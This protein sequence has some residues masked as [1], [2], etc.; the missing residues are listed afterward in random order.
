MGYHVGR[1]RT[2]RAKLP[3]PIH[4]RVGLLLLF[5]SIPPVTIAQNNDDRTATNDS[6]PDRNIKAPISNED[7]EWA[8]H[9]AVDFLWHQQKRVGRW[10]D[11]R[12]SAPYADD[13]TALA[14]YALYRTGSSPD[15]RQFDRA[16][17]YLLD[18]TK[19]PAVFARAHRL[20]LFSSIGLQYF[21]IPIQKDVHFLEVHQ[22]K[23]GAWGS[24]VASDPGDDDKSSDVFHTNLALRALHEAA[25]A[26]ATVTNSVWRRAEQTVLKSQNEDGGWGYT[27]STGEQSSAGTQ[28][29]IG[30]MTA[31]ALAALDIIY[32][33]RYLDAELPFNGRFKAKCGKDVEK[34]QVIRRATR[35]AFTWLENH[36]SVDT[37]PGLSTEAIDDPIVGSLPYHLAQ[38]SGT[39]QLTGPN[40]AVRQKWIRKIATRLIRSQRPD[41]SWGS[42][43]ETSHALLA[44]SDARAPLL[45]SKLV[46]G[47]A[48]QWNLDPRDAVHLTQWCKEEF[49]QPFAWQ[50]V[51]L[52]A[53]EPDINSAPVLLINGHEAPQLTAKQE[54]H[55]RSFVANGGT[56]LASACCSRA[57][58]TKGCG[59]LFS[60]VFPDF[61]SGPL[62]A[63]HAV[64]NILD[65]VKPGEDCIGWGDGCRTSLFLLPNGACCAWQQD[66]RSRERRRFALAGNIVKYATYYQPL[67]SLLKTDKPDPTIVPFATTKVAT[68][69]HGGDSWAEPGALANLRRI[70]A[71]RNGVELQ[72]MPP[73]TASQAADRGVDVLWLTGHTFG[74]L[75]VDEEIALR[76]F[77]KAGG[78]LIVSACCGREAF[79]D[80]FQPFVVELFGAKA[81]V[82]VPPDDSLMTGEFAPGLANSLR[83]L[84]LKLRY[85]G[86]VP[87]RLDRPILYGALID[88]RWAVMY[89]PMDITCGLVGHSCLDCV[90]Y[91][92]RDA[93]SLAA[94]MMLYAVRQKVV[95]KDD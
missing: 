39:A 33:H 13:L 55:L 15:D 49:E 72:L 65:D 6:T 88:D 21:K 56:V 9:R 87:A 89:S 24:G 36:F 32:E 12:P 67:R 82:R 92:S 29:S 11:A 44:L 35:E 2:H 62:D 25:R 17:R 51:E 14:A 57:A 28:T 66:L 43:R 26:G 45:L 46:Y 76:S 7:V 54:D 50:L 22:V 69:R 5:V 78:S 79:D 34:T 58:F 93:R 16:L 3:I 68:L 19:A 70:L 47:D 42:V 83:G 41:G 73:V 63:E 60:K 95:P 75:P 81:W 18:Q 27:L 77:L 64:W 52:D 91:K 80:V 38:L 31:G 84:Q 30:S 90:G 59:E 94:N 10:Y 61:E 4:A 23:R 8:I 1:T 48:A 53:R 37:V 20:L 85:M 71:A 86:N 40:C 74:K